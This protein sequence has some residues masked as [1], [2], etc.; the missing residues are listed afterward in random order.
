MQPLSNSGAN[1]AATVHQ[2]NATANSSVRPSTSDA[3]SEEQRNRR[4]AV[5]RLARGVED[6][7]TKF[8]LLS[9]AESAVGNPSHDVSL[10]LQSKQRQLNDLVRAGLSETVP[11][12]SMGRNVRSAA[13]LSAAMLTRAN[14]ATLGATACMVDGALRSALWSAGIAAMTPVL[15]VASTTHGVVTGGRTG[16]RLGNGM[17]GSAACA[18]GLGVAGAATGSI[19]GLA[20]LAH[21]PATVFTKTVHAAARGSIGRK[22]YRKC[23]FLAGA[24]LHVA[25]QK[26]S[27]ADIAR[28][29]DE[30]ICMALEN[31]R[32]KRLF[33]P[34]DPKAEIGSMVLRSGFTDLYHFRRPG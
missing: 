9:H 10:V 13:R 33:E 15:L 5:K 16:K 8:K 17:A 26:M 31:V 34:L 24:Q 22:I 21:L 3:Q 2:V 19:G 11:P 12:P 28:A 4:H 29:T 30:R 20:Q 18:V 32:R 25:H 23:D 27:T 1:A 6:E 7:F 14:A